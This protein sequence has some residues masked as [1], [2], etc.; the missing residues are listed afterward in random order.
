MSKEPKLEHLDGFTIVGLRARTIN[1]DEFNPATARL[2]LLWQQFANFF[3]NQLQSTS[4]F[5]VYSDY[6][7]DESGFY[8]VTAG[9]MKNLVPTRA[10]LTEITVE[11]GSYLVFEGTGDMPQTVIETWGRVWDYF[12]KDAGYKRCYATD[13]E[14]FQGADRV[15]IHIGVVA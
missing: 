7:S 6:E 10:E 1:R 15:L 4:V 11:S 14:L 13:F 3:P 5:G 2:P 8:S 9:L 12:S